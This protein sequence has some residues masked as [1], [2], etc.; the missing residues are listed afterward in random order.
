[1]EYTVH[2]KQDIFSILTHLPLGIIAV[3]YEM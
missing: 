1:M 3:I 2:E